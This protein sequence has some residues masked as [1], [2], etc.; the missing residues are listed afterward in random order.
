[1]TNAKTKNEITSRKITSTVQMI[2][3]PVFA[4][5]IRVVLSEFEY[6]EQT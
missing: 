2:E 4:P 5:M 6:I 3:S 1:M